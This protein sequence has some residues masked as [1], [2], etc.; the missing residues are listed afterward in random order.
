VANALILLSMTDA[1]DSN[2]S[3]EGQAP[4]FPLEAGETLAR[5]GDYFRAALEALAAAVYTTDAA[6]R[7]TYYNEAAAELWGCRPELGKSEFCGSWKLYWP[8]GKPMRHDECPMAIALKTG[9]AIRGAEAIAERPDGTRV[10]F[11][12]YPTP[13]RDGAGNLVGAVNMLVNITDRKLAEA[14]RQRLAAIVDSSGD[15][16]ISTDLNGNIETWNDGAERLFGYEASEVIGKPLLMIYPPDRQDEEQQILK[17]IRRGEPVDNHETVR[18]RKDGTFIDISLTVSPVREPAGRIIGAS[19]IA[20]NISEQKQAEQASRQLAAIVQSSDDAIVSKDLN[21]IIQSWNAGAERLFGY[22]ADEIIGK[23]VMVLIPPDRH[24]EEPAILQR[25]RRGERVEPY[26]TVRR[27]K[28]GSLIDI[29]LT[30]SPIKDSGGRVIG[31]SKIARD[32][33]ERKRAHARQ[34]L[35]TAEIHHRTKNL[36]A[37]VQAV[38]SRSFAGKLSVEE[39]EAAVRSRLA[40]LAQTHVMLID[41]EWEGADIREVI[42]GEMSP[43]AGRVKVEGSRLLLKPK[44]AQN[45]ALALHELATNAAKYGALSNTTGWVEISWSVGPANGVRGFS[46]RWQEHGGPPVSIPERKGFGSTVLEVV[47]SEYVTEPPRIEFARSGLTYALVAQVEALATAA[48]DESRRATAGAS[49]GQLTET[50]L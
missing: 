12:P 39:A 37:V 16:I 9:Q 22:S 17:S 29:S 34:E 20:R 2:R 50:R 42:A 48:A 14:A 23:P 18:R 27:R 30:V 35:L 28:D 26:E 4:A 15:S 19:R 21:G 38:V 6:G 33:S 24:D 5:G 40:S 32:I 8:D 3:Y 41:N 7:I 49:V 11:I 13:L 36:F 1:V 10:P 46:F 43:Y 25:I 47:M 44:A 31:A 45:F